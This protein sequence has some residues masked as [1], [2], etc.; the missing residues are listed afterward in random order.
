MEDMKT[1]LENVIGIA[2]INEVS[3]GTGGIIKEAV[4]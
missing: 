2:V 4:A 3:K 1:V